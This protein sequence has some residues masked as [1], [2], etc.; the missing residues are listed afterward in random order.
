MD[1]PDSP[2]LFYWQRRGIW[3]KFEPLLTSLCSQLSC[4]SFGLLI[5]IVP[6]KNTQVLNISV[7]SKHTWLHIPSV[8][9]AKTTVLGSARTCPPWSSLD[10]GTGVLLPCYVSRSFSYTQ[11]DKLLGSAVR[12]WP[13]WQLL[14]CG[15][16]QISPLSWCSL[17]PAWVHVPQLQFRAGW[18]CVLPLESFSLRVW[19]CPAF[20]RGMFALCTQSSL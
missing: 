12:L 20:I 9:W 6:N 19:F 8:L 7:G 4:F 15:Q 16:S 14:M 10:D 2:V 18:A 13:C 17:A 11:G 5:A 1:L 3:G